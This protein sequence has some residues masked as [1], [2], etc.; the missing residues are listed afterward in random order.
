M[1]VCVAVQVEVAALIASRPLLATAL[2]TDLPLAAQLAAAPQLLA[3]LPGRPRLAAALEGGAGGGGA[4]GAEAGAEGAAGRA[5]S[6]LAVAVSRLEG[7]AAELGEGAEELLQEVEEEPVGGASRWGG[8][9]GEGGGEQW[10]GMTCH[11]HAKGGA[12]PIA[13]QHPRSPAASCQGQARNRHSGTHCFCTRVSTVP[14]PT[15]VKY[16]WHP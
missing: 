9:G 10:L 5:P 13:C 6:A 14:S 7:F 11:P 4:E 2:A 8:G 16:F 1:C 3:L 12:L 15:S